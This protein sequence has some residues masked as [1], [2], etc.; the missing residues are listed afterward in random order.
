MPNEASTPHWLQMS[1]PG[2]KL[3]VKGLIMKQR[4]DGTW[5]DQ[6]VREITVK[7]SADGVSWKDVI[8]NENIYPGQS[9][10]SILALINI[11]QKIRISGKITYSYM[12]DNMIAL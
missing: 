12:Y 10:G 2:M 1:L 3:V 4:C 7:R 9:I 11:S 8:I 5:I 6:Y